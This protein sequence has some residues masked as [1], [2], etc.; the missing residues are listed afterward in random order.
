MSRMDPSIEELFLR[1]G[2][3]PATRS[4]KAE[5]LFRRLRTEDE[6]DIARALLGAPSQIVLGAAAKKSADK[7]K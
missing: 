3:T 4:A 7:S 5:S 2:A 6:K 1:L